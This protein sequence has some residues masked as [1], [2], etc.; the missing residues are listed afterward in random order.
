MKPEQAQKNLYSD[1]RES[2]AIEQDADLVIF[3]YR[4]EYY[5]IDK[6]EDGNSLKDIAQIIIAK[7]RNGPLKDINL[8]FKSRFAKFNNIENTE[9]IEQDDNFDL[10]PN[11]EFGLKTNHYTSVENE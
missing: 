9:N 7:H 5:K 11:E 2:G 6:D 4:P 8:S 10:T 3:I 1:L